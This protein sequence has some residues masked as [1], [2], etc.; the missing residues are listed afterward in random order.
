MPVGSTQSKLADGFNF[1]CQWIDSNC[2]A[3]IV[4]KDL[5]A[6]KGGDYLP[7]THYAFLFMTL[8]NGSQKWSH[9]EWKSFLLD[10]DNV[11]PKIR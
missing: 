2:L 7:C 10:N 5:E 4:K 6:G 3:Y 11:N 9:K 1:I 8:S